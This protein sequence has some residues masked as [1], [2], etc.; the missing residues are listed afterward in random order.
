MKN[1]SKSRNNTLYLLKLGLVN[2]LIILIGLII[3]EL[4]F[5]NWFHPHR[6]NQLN[7]VRNRTIIYDTSKVYD[8]NNKKAYYKRDKYGFRGVYNDVNNI[9]ILTLGGST[10]DQGYITE[11]ETWQDIIHKD[12]KQEGKSVYVVNAGVNGQSTYGHIKNFEWWFPLIQN[13]RAKYFLFYV[14][15][16]DFYMDTGYKYDNLTLNETPFFEKLKMKSALYY[17]MRQIKYMYLSNRVYKID[18]HRE[19]FDCYQWTDKPLILDYETKI[20]PCL[21]AYERRLRILCDRVNKMGGIPIFVTQQR[22]DYKRIKN[23]VYGVAYSET[24]NGFQYNGID[25]YNALQLLNQRTVKVGN[26]RGAVVIDLANEL[27]LEDGDFHDFLHNTPAGTEKIGH[28]LYNK[29]KHLF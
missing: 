15:I 22:R 2:I 23:K 9:D 1:N 29:L 19:D 7:L 4:I 16:N 11:G 10:T 8:S 17:L 6:L 27:K 18:Y 12:F 28:Y 26:E 21:D 14:G 13:L 5:G 25:F 20:Q 3:L 24:F